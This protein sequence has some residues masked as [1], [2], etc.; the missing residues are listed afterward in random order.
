MKF[1]ANSLDLDLDLTTLSKETIL[2]EGPKSMSAETAIKVL[3]ILA[4]TDKKIA[5]NNGDM[6]IV[7]KGAISDIISMY[8]KDEVF[9]R[10]NFDAPLIFEIRK[11]MLTTI[12]GI[13]KKE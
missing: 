9:W 2:I 11:Y 4:E 5:A 7:L 13:K 6:E 3:G 10:E 12:S 1:T 8:G